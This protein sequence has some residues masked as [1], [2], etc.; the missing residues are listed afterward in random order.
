MKPN[1]IRW[2]D[3][4]QQTIFSPVKRLVFQPDFVSIKPDCHYLDEIVA[5][6]L[7]IYFLPTRDATKPTRAMPIKAI[8]P[9]SGMLIAGAAKATPVVATKVP[10][11]AAKNLLTDFIIT[12]LRVSFR[13]LPTSAVLNRFNRFN[14][15]NHF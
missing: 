15:N 11:T 1:R 5:A 3:V 7:Q 14:V 13:K 12:P 10:A 4:K 9:G 2:A 6:L 8:D